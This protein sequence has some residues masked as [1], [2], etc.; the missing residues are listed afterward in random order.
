MHNIIAVGSNAVWNSRKHQ[1]LGVKQSRLANN[2][3]IHRRLLDVNQKC[4]LGID[5]S[6]PQKLPP[7]KSISKPYKNFDRQCNGFSCNVFLVFFSKTIKFEFFQFPFQNLWKIIVCFKHFFIRWNFSFR[8][9][10]CDAFFLQSFFNR[11]QIKMYC[12]LETWKKYERY[13]W[14]HVYGSRVKRKEY[15]TL[16]RLIWLGDGIVFIFFS[17]QKWA[18][19]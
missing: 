19:N 14:N 5:Y 11:T 8:E 12:Y 17:Q 6:I 1:P 16:C 4:L 13:G 2:S 15:F 9:E 10:N 3:F 18:K 7:A